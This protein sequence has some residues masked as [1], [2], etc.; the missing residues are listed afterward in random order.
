L[1]DVY[2]ANGV[3]NKAAEQY[4]VTA[5]I[6][7]GDAGAKRLA[8][9]SHRALAE[10][11]V[12]LVK[13]STFGALA[14]FPWSWLP[15]NSGN[16][17]GSVNRDLEIQPDS[18]VSSTLRIPLHVAFPRNRYTLDSLPPEAIRQLD[19][20]AALIGTMADRTMKIEIEGHTCTCG[21][22]SA[23]LELGGRRAEAVREF[24]IAKRMVAPDKIKAV[25]FGATRPVESAGAPNLP[26]AVCER[27]AI[28][29]QNRRVV[30]V[31]YVRADS[32]EKKSPRLHVSFLSRRAGTH[33]YEKLPD[34]GQLRTGDLYKIHLRAQTPLY[35]Y[36]FHR[37]SSGKW[38]VLFPAAVVKAGSTP[39]SNPLESEHEISLP[40]ADMGFP[41]IGDPGTEETYIYSRSEPD[42]ILESLIAKIRAGE[43]VREKLLP[44]D[45]LEQDAQG[46]EE[47]STRKSGVPGGSH[48]THAA[49][50]GRTGQTPATPPG[51]P[52]PRPSTQVSEYE[53]QVV[54]KD[55]GDPA[56]G[57]LPQLPSDPVAYVRFK[58]VQ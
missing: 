4:D 53:E 10:A 37:G 13:A 32:P 26:I 54:M 14:E 56:S 58:H 25:S 51:P 38:A 23:N 45:L 44:P 24:L 35:A 43:D 8:S 5:A 27:D 17:E 36:A 52:P 42:P 57:D 11:Q 28:H 49:S 1:G 50:G 15:G 22:A 41:L 2:R 29:S 48:V 46:Q 31:V 9:L 47:Q 12:G 20:V 30:I 7:G 6:D 21:S 33:E 40:N 39:L 34:G 3:W 18:E 16:S 55:L 19:E